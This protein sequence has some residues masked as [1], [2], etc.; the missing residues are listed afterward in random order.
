[1]IDICWRVLC[2]DVNKK[3]IEFYNVFNHC[4]FLL[5]IAKTLSTKIGRAQISKEILSSARHYFFGKTEYEVYVSSITNNKTER[6]IDI[7]D[8]LQNNWCPFITYVIKNRN[9]FVSWYESE[10]Y[11]I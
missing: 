8:Q 2:E 7:Y 4:G 6:K 3:T 5:D 9:K 10:G 1:M 11:K